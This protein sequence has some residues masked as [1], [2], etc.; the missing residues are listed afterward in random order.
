MDG[1]FTQYNVWLQYQIST[2]ASRECMRSSRRYH[3]MTFVRRVTLMLRQRRE[4][5]TASLAKTNRRASASDSEGWDGSNK[6]KNKTPNSHLVRLDRT[7]GM[8]YTDQ[9]FKFYHSS[10]NCNPQE[11]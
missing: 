1:S 5:Q 8:T 2:F 11:T 3:M 10:T 7:V 4:T 6:N 9:Q